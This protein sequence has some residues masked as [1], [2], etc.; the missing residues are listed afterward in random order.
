[1]PTTPTI[2]VNT[3]GL[4]TATVGPKSSTYQLAFQPAKTVTPAATS[5][6]AVSGNYYTGGDVVVAGD[7]NLT[8]E[9]I[10]AGVSIFGVSGA[11]VEG[12]GSES[13]DNEDSLINKTISTYTNNRV[14]S[15]GDYAFYSCTNLTDVSF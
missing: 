1:M 12:G 5:Q 14:S 8:A 11:L 3:S 4:V 9:N 2:S 13:S 15:I 6:I 10:K 7:S